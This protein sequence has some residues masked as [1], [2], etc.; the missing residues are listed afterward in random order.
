VSCRDWRL[1]KVADCK[2]STGGLAKG[3]AGHCHSIGPR[4]GHRQK[5]PG[6]L[7]HGVG[8]ALDTAYCLNDHVTRRVVR[9]PS[10]TSG[11]GCVC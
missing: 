10:W 1:C 6:R 11:V 7:R 8:A 2:K 9:T 4:T 5:V 3:N